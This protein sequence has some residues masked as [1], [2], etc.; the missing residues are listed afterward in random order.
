MPETD[1]KELVCPTLHLNGS[2]FENLE[3]DLTNCLDTLRAAMD[4]LADATPHGRDYYVQPAGSYEKA[5]E[6]HAYRRQKLADVYAEIEQVYRDVYR[7][8]HNR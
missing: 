7:Q 2:G 1:N 8:H 3:A 5:R 6:Q 4:A